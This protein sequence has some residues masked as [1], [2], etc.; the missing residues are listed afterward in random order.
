MCEACEIRD[1]TNK[2]VALMQKEGLMP[3]DLKDG[4]ELKQANVMLKTMLQLCAS[5][6]VSVAGTEGEMLQKI[7]NLCGLIFADAMGNVVAQVEAVEAA[8]KPAATREAA[9]AAFDGLMVGS[10][11]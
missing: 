6:T 4:A 5:I 7:A 11:H 1:L 3:A 2:L 10:K 9:K 8:Q